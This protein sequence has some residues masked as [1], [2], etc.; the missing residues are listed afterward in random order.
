MTFFKKRPKTYRGALKEIPKKAKK[1]PCRLNPSIQVRRSEKS[2][3]ESGFAY[4]LEGLPLNPIGSESLDEEIYDG[5][6]GR[7]D[8]I[9]IPRCR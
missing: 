4:P 9:V 6:R 7:S 5:E 1:R 2:H 3:S 8:V